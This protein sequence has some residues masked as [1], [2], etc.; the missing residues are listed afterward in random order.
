MLSERIDSGEGSQSNARYL[1]PGEEAYWYEIVPKSVRTLVLVMVA[2]NPN[3]RLTLNEI[4]MHSWLSPN[5][6]AQ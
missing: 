3:E 4:E 1:K 2:T 6:H 5:R